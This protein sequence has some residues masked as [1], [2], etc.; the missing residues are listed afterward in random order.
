MSET[1]F[2]IWF[3]SSAL[4]DLRGC[5]RLGHY[6]HFRKLAPI[7]AKV[8]INA[9]GA[10]ARGLEVARKSFYRDGLDEETS[11]ARGLRACIQAYGPE[12]WA[13][14]PKTWDRVAGA[15]VY[16][17]DQFP[18]SS[19]LLK[20]MMV[21][22]KITVEFSFSE[23]LPIAHPETGE[24]ILMVGRAD[25]LAL[26][27]G[28]TPFLV[29]EKTTKSLGAKWPHQ[30]PLRGQF[31]GYTWAARKRGFKVAGTIVRGIAILKE[32][33]SHAEAILYHQDWMIEEWMQVTL[34]TI[35]GAIAMWKAGRFPKNFG[36]TCE[37]YG[38]CTFAPL[39]QLRD[40]EPWI[41]QLYVTRD[42]NPLE[43]EDE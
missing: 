25:L 18:L 6:K 21:E 29:D 16:Y 42:W 9:G 26:Y 11:I 2:P 5:A 23:Q 15:L 24:P 7:K 30:W 22:G 35:E 43:K 4:A 36:M 8:D 19:D 13:D 33:Y 41:S 32:K 10:F 1:T 38:G 14:T 17:F 39:C 34:D 27:K 31:I 3:D 37:K 12:D 28:E 20:P 40:P